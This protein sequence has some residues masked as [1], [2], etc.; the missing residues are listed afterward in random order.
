MNRTQSFAVLFALLA[1]TAFA[2]SPKPVVVYTFLCKGSA[3]SRTGPCPD[4]GIPYALLQG[5]DGSFYG[6][7]QVSSEGTSNNGGR[8]FRSP[9]AGSL[10]C[11]IR[12]ARDQLRRTRTATTPA[13]WSKGLTANSTARPFMAVLIA[14]LAMES[15]SE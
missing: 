9:L 8:Y 7:A 2:A 15:C 6:N 13:Y 10:R 5:S 4:G 12:S 1:T 11:C 3:F 14:L